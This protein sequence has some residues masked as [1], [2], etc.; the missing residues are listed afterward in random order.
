MLNNEKAPSN[1]EVIELIRSYGEENS[2]EVLSSVQADEG[3]GLSMDVDQGF[4]DMFEAKYPGVS[5]DSTLQ[6][7]FEDSI[8]AFILE[9]EADPEFAEKMKNMASEKE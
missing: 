8:K 7:F 4:I 5:L 6:T 3:E 1:E 9:M 2:I